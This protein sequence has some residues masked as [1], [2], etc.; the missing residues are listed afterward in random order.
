MR[1]SPG[2]TVLVTN[3]HILV[4]SPFSPYILITC[5]VSYDNVKLLRFVSLWDKYNTR[6]CSYYEPT[7]PTH[8]S[9]TVGDQVSGSLFAP[10]RGGAGTL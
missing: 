2:G 5:R 4:C 6:N 1:S 3:C 8:G 10:E 9:R 7:V